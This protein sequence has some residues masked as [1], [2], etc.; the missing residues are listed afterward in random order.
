M[1]EYLHSEAEES[2]DELDELS[3]EEKKRLKKLK[4]VQEDDEEEEDDEEQL[5]EELKDLIDDNEEE[6]ESDSDDSEIGRKRKN[7]DDDDFDDRLE[8]EDYDLIEE[9]LGVK[10]Q[11]RQ[12]KRV[13]RVDDDESDEDDNEAMNVPAE[14]ERDA[15]ANELF[16]GSDEE[17]AD[18]RAEASQQ[19]DGYQDLSESEGEYSET[20]GFIVD[21]YGQPIMK[22]KRKRPRYTDAA[23]QEAQD[24]FG[25]DFD[26]DEFQTYGEDYDEEMDEE[27]GY[28]EEEVDGEVRPRAKKSARKKS[29]KKSI[30]EVYEPSELERGHFTDKDN[31][32][33]V[34]DI[35][36]RFQLRGEPVTGAEED[37]LREEAEW[38]YKFAFCTPAISTQDK[39]SPGEEQTG[40]FAPS[41]KGPSTT[42]KIKEALNFMRNQQFEVPF[43]AFY[44][45]EYVEPDLNINDLWK[46]FK[47]DEKWCQLQKRKKTMTSLLQN[48]QQV[49]CD[50]IMKD[51]DK[52]LA[53]DLRVLSNDDIERLKGIQTIEELRDTYLH[54]ILYYGK[55][56]P[57]MQEMLQ[58]KK[59]EE[60]KERRLKKK[61]DEET[62]EEKEEGAVEEEEEEEEREEENENEK[63]KQAVFTDSYSMCLRA[64]IGGL[65]K[66][67]GLT[68]QQFGENMRD[69]YTRH[70]VEQYPVEPLEVS[71]DYVCSKFPTPEEVLK[72]A[73]F[74]VATQLSREPLVRQCVRTTYFERAKLSIKPTK[75][76]IKEID[77]NH[78]CFT[79]KYLKNKPV[80]DL[81]GDMYL[82]IHLA[83]EEKLITTRISMEGDTS[84]SGSNRG[85]YTGYLDE[86]KQLYYRDEFSK[87]VQEWNTQRAKVLELTLTKFLYP[88]YEK[89]LRA[90]LL[91]E[92][93]DCVIKACS[94][95]LFNWLKVAP[96][97]V[98]QGMDDDEDYDTSNGIRVMAISYVPDW[99]TAAFSALVAGDGEVTDYLRLPNI[100][101]RKNAWKESD[102]EAKQVDINNVRK[103]IIAKKPHVIAVGAE[104]RDALMILE[105]I[106]AIV[107]ELV[108]SEQMPNI[109]V[110]LVDTELGNVYMKSKKAES[111]FR[112]YPLLLRQAISLARCLQDPLI[113]FSQ[114]CGPDDEILC[115]KYHSLQDAVVKEDLLEAIQL[116]F[117]NRTNE[118][119]V[120]V[121]R[122]IANPH[123]GNLLQFVCG[124]GPRKAAALIKVLKQTNN[125]LENRTQLVTVCHMG[126]KVFINCAGFIKI[127]TNSLGDSTDAYVEVL[128]GSRVH[129]ETYEWARKMAVDALEYDDMA[130]DANPAG[131][132]EE[133]LE[134][135]EKLK[136]LDLDAFAE[137]L[138]RQGYGNKSITLYDIRA[139]LNHRYKD[140]RTAYRSANTEERF[141][142]CTKETP[143]TFFIGK[144]VLAKV[145]GIAHKKP[146]GEQL[147]QANPVRNDE[148][149]LWQC[150]FCLKNDFL[151]VSEVWNHFDAGSCPGQAMGVRARLD[152]GVSGFILTKNISDKHVTNPEERVKIGM[153]LHCRIMK[154]DIE[155]FQVDLTCRSSDLAD[156]NNEWRPPKDAYYDEESEEK[157]RK[158][159]EDHK[160]R[161]AR[162]TYV[163][164]VIV[165]P[166]F[167]NIDFRETE[168]LMNTMDQGEVIVRPSSKGTDHL[169][170]TWKV[171]DGI[172][173][174][175]DI[176]EEGK[177]N[178]FSLG[179]SLWI[180]GEEFEDLDE[181]IARHI[182]PM[183]AFARDLI[184]F[185]YF[186]DTDGGKK[187]MSEKY[188]MEEKKKCPSKIPYMLSASRDYPGKFLLSYLPRTKCRHEYIT[189]TPEGFKYRQQIFHSHNSLLRWFKEHFRDP[190]PGT[191]GSVTG[192]TPMIQSAYT[193]P[194]INIANLDPQAIQRAAA[195]IPSHVYN[196]LSQVA[197]QT[198]S[199]HNSHYSGYGGYSYHAQ[200]PYT[201]SQP[202]ATPLLTPSYHP[203]ATPSHSV[204]TPRYQPTPQTWAHPGQ[205]PRTPSQRSSSTV[206]AKPQA[207][208]E[209]DWR[210]A[211]EMWAKRRQQQQP[212][213]ATPRGN[214]TPRITPRASP[215]IRNSPMVESTPAGDATP[216]I[217]EH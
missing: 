37:E 202:I 16:E 139:E 110:E 200:T 156:K 15:I 171:T 199:I 68:P 87:N 211:A 160:K 164:R 216:L 21:D 23:L 116:E 66:K 173:Q 152:N 79:V 91:Q 14:D 61:Y 213:N 49:Q 63:I 93:K 209:V 187:E 123:T 210:K 57:K 56:I 94:Q 70:E 90:K 41:R 85:N 128:D 148:T 174:H 217:D 36:E 134:N 161:Q 143:E 114:L 65:V 34:T 3:A 197:S 183:A 180:G 35:P 76:G 132:L 155:R 75:K 142:M 86:I 2:D 12:F 17:G 103:F 105:D 124:L 172:C 30:F 117:I 126:P 189:I 96:Y 204:T 107:A 38:I 176:R 42:G 80:K 13:R 82:K 181:I 154:I 138:A 182:Q 60:R 43:I 7:E 59:R 40:L 214:I 95:K 88:V 19:D 153:T 119:G 44:R 178:T 53:D 168:K 122:S 62:G 201:P 74:M 167:H 1:A 150:P 113:E 130:E 50:E 51:P 108:E 163:K 184:N 177:E 195:N 145:I 20:D 54:F 4:Q 192:R 8:D 112:D 28:E 120:D 170:V 22:A 206:A 89:E 203:I 162:Q 157:D 147:D 104:S 72:A 109:G 46:V 102:R 69:N 125:R 196:T 47:W 159:E 32:I 165:H 141:N 136:D 207:N 190:I 27:M 97:T 121:N 101:K 158:A 169:T 185:K 140:L 135:P 208:T 127:D 9:N 52:P 118:V 18:R 67:F 99:D 83:S 111:D 198:P 193:T 64:G 191:P 146:Q 84:N 81:V 71:Q 188:L 205:T 215:A 149:G 39:Q 45:K 100:L 179:Q 129:P 98:D 212:G 77:E 144:L 25:V 194:S 175:I 31:E 131:A 24:I 11:R 73:R 6:V 10:V 33:R 29:T 5:A 58:K 133:I 186:R 115:L 137:E 166:S 151:E 55:D 106:K 48:M 26:Y 92:A 78:P